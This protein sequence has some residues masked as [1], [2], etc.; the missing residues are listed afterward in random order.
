MMKGVLSMK[1]QLINSY[2]LNKDL[3]IHLTNKYTKPQ[4]KKQ[5]YQHLYCIF[6]NNTFKKGNT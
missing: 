3:Y 5:K 2:L 4:T 6:R 1:E